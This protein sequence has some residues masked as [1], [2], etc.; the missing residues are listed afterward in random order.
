MIHVSRAQ[1]S[2]TRLARF[3]C[4]MGKGLSLIHPC[5]QY[6]LLCMSRLLLFPF[7]LPLLFLRLIH[8]MTSSIIEELYIY[9]R[10]R[11]RP[12]AMRWCHTA[13]PKLHDA[14]RHV[15]SPISVQSNHAAAYISALQT[16]RCDLL[17][18]HWHLIPPPAYLLIDI[19][20]I[21]IQHVLLHYSPRLS[22][23]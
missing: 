3:T 14:T 1:D 18:H 12:T 6:R 2:H 10:G 15:Q 17:L 19:S 16:T 23:V 5:D 21:L 4:I 11:L 7:P 9:V 13:A 22:P 20:E 8:C